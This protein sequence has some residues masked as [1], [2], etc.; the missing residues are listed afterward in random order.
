[1]NTEEIRISF[2]VIR[3]PDLA[4]GRCFICPPARDHRRSLVSFQSSAL[5]KSAVYRPET[6]KRPTLSQVWA[7]Y[8]SR[9]G[10]PGK[11]RTRAIACSFFSRV[12][13]RAW[14]ES[15][16]PAVLTWSK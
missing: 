13:R 8:R 7:M 2:R 10:T 4:I 1:M 6:F 14:T 11:W 9:E 5:H 12:R 16:P 3:G 15:V